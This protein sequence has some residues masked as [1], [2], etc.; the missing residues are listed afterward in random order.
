MKRGKLKRAFRKMRERARELFS[1]YFMPPEN[2]CM[3]PA[4]AY[5]CT[6]ASYLHYSNDSKNQVMHFNT[7]KLPS[8]GTP[9][10][11]IAEWDE[12]RMDFNEAQ[13]LVREMLN[14]KGA[15]HEYIA[16]EAAKLINDAEVTEYTGNIMLGACCED[17]VFK[18]G[19]SLEDLYAKA[20]KR[21]FRSR[22]EYAA[23]I[24]PRDEMEVPSFLQGLFTV[25]ARIWR[26]ITGSI[27]DDAINRPYMAHFYDP[28]R[29]KNDQGLNVASGEIKF[30]SALQ[31]IKDYWKLAY[32]FYA[33]GKKSR[34]YYALGHI[35]HLISDL[36]V[37]AHVH[38]DI[39]GPTVLLGKLD[40]LEQWTMKSDYN[41][42]KRGK[43]KMNITIWDSGPLNPPFA[44]ASWNPQNIDEKLEEFVERIATKTQFFRS[45]D[46]HGTGQHE[47][48][49]GKLSDDECYKQASV[50]IPNA[51]SASAQIIQNFIAYCKNEKT[52]FNH[53]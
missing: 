51:I 53:S 7:G 34:A 50:L 28:T 26:R 14:N 17:Y 40:S 10:R 42:L 3:Q 12:V 46:A 41:H 13:M 32:R 23:L 18:P 15:C 29:D 47:R 9:G 2:L 35:V 48:R 4:Y 21:A 36:H 30:Q 16:Y 19:E 43:G 1:Q 11:K 24:V 38:N 20:P 52:S 45:V 33:N 8:R 39:H 27:E 49:K 31:R 37:P 22:D 6:L 25:T 5:A 44:D